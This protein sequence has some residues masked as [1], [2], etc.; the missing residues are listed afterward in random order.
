MHNSSRSIILE[1]RIVSA[2]DTA[3]ESVDL[4]LLK[5]RSRSLRMYSGELRVAILTDISIRPSF[6]FRA[7][8][9]PT[10]SLMPQAIVVLPTLVTADPSA[11]RIDPADI[12]VSLTSISSLPS[13]R[14]P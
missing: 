10:S 8:G 9:V 11:E 4:S 5:L 1:F 3:M 6:G 13:G 12:V 14:I 2:I 7:E